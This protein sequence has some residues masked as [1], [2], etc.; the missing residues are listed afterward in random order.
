MEP[1]PTKTLLS[2]LPLEK[3]KK[4][5]KEMKISAPLNVRHVGMP[6]VTHLSDPLPAQSNFPVEV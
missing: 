2:S 1:A 3:S 5:K 4:E 6:G